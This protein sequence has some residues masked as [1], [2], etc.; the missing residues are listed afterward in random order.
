MGVF[1]F[2]FFFVARG[3]AERPSL[4][5]QSAQ[6]ERPDVVEF[7]IRGQVEVLSG[8]LVN[9][10]EAQQVEEQGMII[11]IKLAGSPWL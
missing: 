9:L 3:Q 11:G 10:V 6:N 8:V 4:T 1:L 2:W 5:L 7:H